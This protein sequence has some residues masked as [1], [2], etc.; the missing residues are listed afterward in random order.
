[1]IKGS[2]VALITPFSESGKVNINKLKELIDFHINNKT[3]AVLLFGTTGEGSTLCLKEKYKLAK[4]ITKYVNKRI[5]IIINAGDNDTLKTIKNVKKYSKLKP[6]ALLII[7]PYYNKTNK[8]GLYRHFSLIA[9]KTDISIIIYNV[10][11]RTSIDLPLDIIERLSLVPNIIGIKEASNNISKLKKLNKLQNENFYWFSGN[12]TRMV[13]DIKLGAKGLIGVVTNSHPK[14]IKEILDLSLENK[15]KQAKEKYS[16]LKE[17]IESLYL[18]PNPIPIKE[19]MN[20][21][22]FKVGKYRLPLYQMSEDNKKMLIKAIE[23]I[24]L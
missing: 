15:Y 12:D 2:I 23:K 10:P 7:T 19:A 11:S 13:E 1:M 8:E 14:L 18:E 16:F 4:I 20:I 3:D 6:Y 17:Y 22:G 9:S 21:L 5:K 24:E